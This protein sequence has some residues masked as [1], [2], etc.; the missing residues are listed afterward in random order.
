M[1]IRHIS[2]H[3]LRLFLSLGKHLSFTKAAE[4]LYLT[5]PA[6][7]IQIKR[8]EEAIGISL[9][10]KMGKKIFLTSAGKEFFSAAQDIMDRL[11]VLSE[12]LTNMEK[13]ITG[14]LN[15]TAISTAKYFMPHFLG[16]FL[17]AYPGVE[18]SL[19]IT[20]QSLVL[21]QL[22][23]NIDDIVI[24]GRV[25]AND[26]KL[27]AHKFLDNP[28][29]V[30][31]P[32]DHPLAKEKNIPLKTISHERFISREAGSGTRE[33]RS[34]LFAEHGLATKTYMELGS[35]EAVKQ[36]VMAGLGISVMSKHNLRLELEAGLVTILDVEH[37][38]LEKTWYAVHLKG[39]KLSKTS[40]HFLEFLL[41]DGCRTWKNM[42]ND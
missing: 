39:K 20:N 6:V 33:A 18:P 35:S 8:L 22:R 32:S 25:P 9:V 11:K 28:L 37:F 14:P 5:Q 30:V 17:K 2:L 36:A 16:I 31:A 7:S 10:D 1:D 12:D 13:G 29:I 26:N 27:V 3:Q 4:E 21:Q 38:P 41:N 42:F 19:N 23:D 15:I 40:Q 24:M 34:R